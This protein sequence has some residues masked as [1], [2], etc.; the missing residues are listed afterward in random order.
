MLLHVATPVCCPCIC[1]TKAGVW[2]KPPANLYPVVE[3]SPP[4]ARFAFERTGLSILI[5]GYL[6]IRSLCRATALSQMLH[7]K[8][9]KDVAELPRTPRN[10]YCAVHLAS[11]ERSSSFF[12]TSEASVIG[13]EIPNFG[14]FLSAWLPLF[15]RTCRRASPGGNGQTP[16]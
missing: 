5:F 12:D 2:A 4:G 9:F 7:L 11:S 1:C 3:F 15:H 16:N 10:R 8:I 13:G 14:A 6:D